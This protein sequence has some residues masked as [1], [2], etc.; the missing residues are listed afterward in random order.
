MGNSLIDSA[1]LLTFFKKEEPLDL[2]HQENDWKSWLIN[3]KKEN[4]I[5]LSE[6]GEESLTLI[7]FLNKI[8]IIH[9]F[10][11]F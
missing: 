7:E 8:L 10:D 4:F 9:Y 2:H 6:A 1:Y 3:I 11:G 5:Y